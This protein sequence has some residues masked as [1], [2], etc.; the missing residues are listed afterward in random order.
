MPMKLEIVKET[1]NKT[2]ARKEV[3]F[4][5][6]HQGGTTPSRA[7][8]R[9]KIVAQ[10]DASADTVVVRSLT[11]KF[12]VGI[13]EGIAR[14]YNDAGQLKRIELNHIQKRHGSEKKEGEGE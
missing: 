8:V 11:T 13:S 1:E 12:G 10:F 14:I 4:V 5:I 7:D 3:E 6:D 9:D 2:L